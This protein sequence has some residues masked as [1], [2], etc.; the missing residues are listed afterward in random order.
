MAGRLGPKDW[1][2]AAALVVAVLLV[3]HPAWQGGLIWDDDAHITRPELQSGHGLYRIWFDVR[4]TL[5]YYPLLH[6]AFWLEH[7]LWGDATVGYHLLNLLLHATAALLVALILRRLRVPGAYL[8]AAIFAL[9]P[10]NV[11]S[12]AWIAEQKNTLSGVFYLAALLIYLHFDQTRKPAWYLG[13]LALFVLG[14]MSKTVIATL[15]GALLVILWW[16]RGRLLWKGDVVPLLPWFVLGAAGG[17]ITAWWELQINECIGPDFT[18]T[19]VERCLIAG[20]TVCFLLWKLVW[21][22]QLAFIYPRWQI[23][24][25][26]WWQYL[27]PLGTVALS[28]VLWSIRRWTCAPLAALL[29]FGG[30]LFP[31][32]GFFNL[33]TFRYSFVANHYQ[34]LASLGIITLAAAG[35][36]L[37]LA[38]WRQWHRLAAYAV[39]LA[40]LATLASLTWRQSQMFAQSETLYRTT[41]E[42]NPDCW[43]AYNN[44]GAALADR[45]QSEEAIAQYRK[46]LEI[47]PDHAGAHYN[48]ANV[49]ARRG[50]LDQAIAHYQKSLEIKPDYTDAHNNL[51]LA[52]ARRGRFDEAI[53]HY[54]IALEVKPDYVAV[55]NNL[56]NA[57][58]RS[59]RVDE[60]ITQYQKALEFKPDDGADYVAA[61]YDL[62]VALVRKGQL[63]EAISH[64]QK[65]LEINPGHLETL[66]NF[67][68]ALAQCGRLDEAIAEYKK[69]LQIKPSYADARNNLGIAESKREAIRQTMVEKRELLRSRP[70]DLALLNDIAWLLATNPNASLRHG[71]EAIALAEQAA[72]LSDR[73]EPAILGTLAAAYA[74]AGRFSE[75]VQTA[76][77]ALDLAT[78][79]TKQ[80]LAESLKAKIPLYEA[81]VPFRDM[82]QSAPFGSVRP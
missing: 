72:E 30:T 54:R 41:I 29:Y 26:S 57:L 70:N 49:L 12:V 81:G 1:L 35:L 8:A 3:Y 56:G 32:L 28:A 75:A 43:L 9:H 46:A 4:A 50:E 63:R 64:Y 16:Q 60:A 58:A 7:R 17:L 42:E 65:V 71:A 36:A 6:S 21:P 55:Y 20:R 62:A 25:G 14:V 33:Y 19:L 79:Q 59:G 18:F 47:K 38:R 52:L 40:L 51:G 2:F 23:D 10:I 74:E 39:S 53:A 48:L 11:E 77:K 78:E 66:N 82:Q 15:P 45:G 31:M 61:H 13:S 27:F 34:Y 76:R 69:A 44:L 22:T 68:L 24:T 67:G 37:L 5:Q 80:S 73:R